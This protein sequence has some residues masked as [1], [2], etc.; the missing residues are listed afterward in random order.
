M[1]RRRHGFTLVELLVYIVIATIVVGIAGQAF[2]EAA[3]SKLRTTG[4]LEAST[5]TSDVVDYLQ[6]D[7]RRAGAKTWMLGSSS[8]GT[9]ATSS[10]TLPKLA[11][12]YWDPDNVS[13]PDSSS[14]L[15]TSSGSGAHRLDELVFLA[16]VYGSDGKLESYEK[17]RYHVDNRVLWRTVVAQNMLSGSAITP[18]PGA[19]RIAENVV[20]FKL[21]YGKRAMHTAVLRRA[22]VEPCPGTENSNEACLVQSG[23]SANLSAS[24]GKPRVY[25]LPLG[26][27][28]AFEVKKTTSVDASFTVRPGY[29]YRVEFGLQSNDSA[30]AY[31]RSDRDYIAVAVTPA[32]TPGTLLGGQQPVLFYSALNTDMVDRS[33]EFTA[34]SS[35]SAAL[36]FRFQLRSSSSGAMPSSS[37]AGSSSSGPLGMAAAAF[38]IDS[39][40]VWEQGRDAYEWIDA[41][42]ATNAVAVAGKAQVKAIEMTI[43]VQGKAAVST[44]T[45]VIP[46]LNNGE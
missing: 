7:I 27:M 25:G 10:A 12:I 43:S 28:A 23:S 14:F 42:D 17:I 39:V 36:A 37:S 16:G 22:L 46:V 6:E 19:V 26:S 30:A 13:L 15:G 20:G 9:S 29:T 33:F 40:I 24:S 4:L 34:N 44:V 32:G 45:K 38:V 18:L 3:R 21:R 41:F 2:V 31:F 5:V 1:M 11:A 35:A 8:S